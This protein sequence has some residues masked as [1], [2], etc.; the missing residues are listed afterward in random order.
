MD[1]KVKLF[2]VFQE[3]VGESQIIISAGDIRELIDK[4]TDQYD[5]LEDK[6]FS[7]SRDKLRSGINIMVNGRSIRFLNGFDTNL[8][9]G[10][11]VTIFPPV[12]GG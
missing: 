7:D 5:E 2:A 10:D 8:K 12:A 3:I 11:T 1:V 6:L 9:D 4:L